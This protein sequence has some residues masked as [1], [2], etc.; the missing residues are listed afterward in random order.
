[1]DSWWKHMKI[2]ITTKGIDKG[3]TTV[4]WIIDTDT[5]IIL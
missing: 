3:E 2:Y 1:M 4:N 5:G